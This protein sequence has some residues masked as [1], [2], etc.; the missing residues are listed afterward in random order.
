MGMLRLVLPVEVC[1]A[2]G[3]LDVQDDA[4]SY[5]TA[6][7]VILPAVEFAKGRIDDLDDIFAAK[8]RGLVTHGEPP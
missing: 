6:G 8:R 7:V 3:V 2:R 5:G 4:L 1:L